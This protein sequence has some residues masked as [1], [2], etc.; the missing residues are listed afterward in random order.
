MADSDLTSATRTSLLDSSHGDPPVDPAFD[1][2]PQQQRRLPWRS[3]SSAPPE[4]GA[5]LHPAPEQLWLDEIL[6]CWSPDIVHT[7]GLDG[8]SYFYLSVRRWSQAAH[9]PC[10][11]V[12]ALRGRDRSSSCTGSAAKH[13][14]LIDEAIRDCDQIV[15][16]NQLNYDTCRE[17]GVPESRLSPLGIMPGT[18]GL[19]VEEF[20]KTRSGLPSTRPRLIL[21]PKAYE[22]PYSKAVP[23]LEALRLAWDRIRPCKITA[24]AVV[25]SEIRMWAQ[26]LPADLR[27]SIEMR[28]RIPREEVLALMGQA[29][30]M[31]APSLSDGIPNCL[32]EAMA[33]GALPIVS[34]LETITPFAKAEKNVLYA[35]NLYP[36]EIA[37]ALV[38]A[39]ER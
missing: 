16:D 22:S 36:S 32:Y 13:V 33:A 11:I 5:G 14:P 23:V 10:W 28:D 18:G 1:P 30:V 6:R 9:R 31:L 7:F 12:L 25:Q 20:A 19:D 27:D 35:R 4:P 37:E 17:L 3:S 29:R 24:L 21:W 26:T 34:P 2:P 15:A 39:D 38:R 8:S